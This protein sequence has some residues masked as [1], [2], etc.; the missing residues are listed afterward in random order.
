M[1]I[2]WFVAVLAAG[3]SFSV[4]AATVNVAT[5]A[6]LI[7]AVQNASAGDEIVVKASGSPYLFSSDQKDVVG[8][9]Y[10]RVSITL[11][12]ET[13]N[14]E[15]VVLVGNANRILYLLKVGNTIRDLTFRNGDCTSYS[16]RGEEPRDALRGGAITTQPALDTSTVI[17]NCVFESCRSSA[18]GGACGTYTYNNACFGNFIDCTFTGNS[19]S[20]ISGGALYQAYSIRRCT[21]RN[22]S[23]TGASSNGGAVC[24]AKEIVGSTFEENALTN[25][26]GSSYGGGAVYLPTNTRYDSVMISNCT[27]TANSTKKQ[28]GGAI[29]N[30]HTGLSVVDSVFNGNSTSSGYG[31]ALANVPLVRGCKIVSNT[32]SPSDAFGGGVYDCTL[33]GCYIA[34]NYAYRCGA[35]ADSRLY[36]CTNVANTSGDFHE[37]GPASGG[38][39][40][41]AEDC[42]FND[43]GASNKRV[44]GSSGFNRC[45]F[46]NVKAGSRL[47]TTYVAMTN[48]LVANCRSNFTLL[49]NVSAPSGWINCTIVSNVY[50]LVGGDANSAVLTV[51]NCF[52][53]GNNIGSD[54]VDINSSASSVVSSIKNS[55][56]SAAEDSYIPDYANSNCL[57]IYGSS[58]FDPGFVGVEKDPEN[59]FAITRKSPA[60]EKAGVVED[61]MATATDIRGDGFPRLRDG[62]VNIGCYQCWDKDSGLTIFVR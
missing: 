58:T 18:G 2:Q 10:A 33:T 1:K 5:V 19:T 15:D 29:R 62:L 28:Y 7:N 8:H 51:K 6:D 35:A 27:F 44:F 14:P 3:L 60:F 55:I 45:R 21:F 32:T 24:G 30:A 26:G 16:V 56:L 4:L 46:A 57:N 38:W 43:V 49:Y 59:P 41:Y 37:F 53:H 13:G 22:N 54:I 23:A 34:S 61:W 39:G 11:R 52:F 9:L 25:D 31:G 36:A 40:C 42:V 20:G 47:F 12:G 17:S 48:S 50:T